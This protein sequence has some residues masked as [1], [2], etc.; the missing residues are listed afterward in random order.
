M[1]VSNSLF[2]GI[3]RAK[4]KVSST[5]AAVTAASTVALMAVSGGTALA[6]ISNNYSLFGD[7]AIVSGGNPGNAAQIGNGS[8]TSFGGVDY[9]DTGAVTLSQLNQLSTD[10]KFTQ[11]TCGV[12]SP[13]YG[14]TV[15]NGTNT[16]T[17]FFYIGPPPSYTGCPPNVWTNT[18]NLAAPTNLVDTSQLP[19]GAFYD[20][21]A[22][23]QVKYGSYTI[24][25]LFVVADNSF[26]APQ[27]LL[28]DNTQVNNF[29]YTFDQPQNKDAC[30]NGGWQTLTDNNGNHFKN[31]GD[32]VSYVATGGKNQAGGH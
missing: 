7:S 5:L 28:I 12:G 17:I 8:G 9:N 6:A 10:Y 20:P 1:G 21:Y 19:G 24:T 27:T 22:A 26:P 25:D 15:T 16:G 29:T 23:A 32:C 11:G 30:K 3:N 14:A 18:G 13:R 4:R 2:T 31:Q